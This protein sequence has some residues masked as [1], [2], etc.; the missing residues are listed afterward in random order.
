MTFSIGTT[1]A[2]AS[3]AVTATK[4]ALKLAYE[5]RGTS[6]KAARTASSAKAPGSPAYAI[7]VALTGPSLSTASAVGSLGEA[8]LARPVR[9]LHH[10]QFRSRALYSMHTWSPGPAR[11]VHLTRFIRE[12]PPSASHRGGNLALDAIGLHGS[13]RSLAPTDGTCDGCNADG[14]RR[15]WAPVHPVVPM[16][17]LRLAARSRPLPLARAATARPAATARTRRRCRARPLP[18]RSPLAARGPSRPTPLPACC[19]RPRR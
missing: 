4:T 3:S 1:P 12:S 2:F 18:C 7:G 9:S 10:V 19:S 15:G 11:T 6:P 14:R 13:A 16:A 8:L 5:A 17:A